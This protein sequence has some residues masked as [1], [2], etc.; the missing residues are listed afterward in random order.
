[1]RFILLSAMEW[2]IMDFCH[3]QPRASVGNTRSVARFPVGEYL[4]FLKCHE[5]CRHELSIV[6]LIM[7][8]DFS[9]AMEFIIVGFIYAACNLVRGMAF[10]AYWYLSRNVMLVAGEEHRRILNVT[11]LVTS[12]ELHSFGRM[13]PWEGMMW[14]LVLFIKIYF[15]FILVHLEWFRTS[16]APSASPRSDVVSPVSVQRTKDVPNLQSYAVPLMVFS[17]WAWYYFLSSLW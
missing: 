1:M 16:R 6:V 2:F 11:S 15:H 5:L 4:W 7:L 13:T 3:G 8:L 12:C 9:S 10:G 17:L 14:T